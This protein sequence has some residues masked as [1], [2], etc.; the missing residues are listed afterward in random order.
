MRKPVRAE[1]GVCFCLYLLFM[2]VSKEL[3]SGVCSRN[4]FQRGV[5][6]RRVSIELL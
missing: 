5:V 1:I 6:R 2:S 3:A 4:P